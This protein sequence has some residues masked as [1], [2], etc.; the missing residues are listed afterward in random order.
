MSGEQEKTQT[1]KKGVAIRS[2][3]MLLA[4]IVCILTVITI[5]ATHSTNQSYIRM[6]EATERFI[7]AREAA[8]SMQ[9]ASDY[10][11]E[12]ART[13]VITGNRKNVDAFFTE[14]KETRRRDQALESLGSY[15]GETEAYQALRN[16]L[17]G[18]NELVN[19]ENYAMRVAL[20]AY[21]YNV[22]DFPEELRTVELTAADA[23]LDARG[24]LSLATRLVFGEE[25]QAQKTAIYEE[26][27][28][29]LD[30][31]ISRSE[32]GQ[33]ESAQRMDVMLKVRT[34]LLVVI[35]AAFFVL[36]LCSYFLVVK[37]LNRANA[38][39][40]RQEYLPVSGSEEV[41]F[42][43]ETYNQM[44][45]QT[46][47]DQEQL[48]YEASHDS[49][50]GLYNRG[51]FEKQRGE[52]EH[53]NIAMVLADVDRFKTI[54]DT[55]GHDTGDRILKKVAGLLKKSFRSED[56]VCRIGGDEFAVIM[57]HSDSSL[58]G[59]VRDK[60]EKVN[61]ALAEPEDG[62]P[63]VSLSIGVA[64]GDRENPTEDIFKDADTA[65]Y[66]VKNSG[67]NAV[68]FY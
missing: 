63:V 33:E 1:H 47:K 38:L 10:L 40:R 29:C 18:S 66:S 23:A 58:R 55:Y 48:S 3:Y 56:Y 61:A 2:I 51:V 6:Q 34:T 21:G 30:I 54:N 41:R 22:K 11:T 35:L 67:G 27:G 17:D 62:L 20:D 15:Y 42:L 46:R 28:R 50:T 52:L 24:K 59:L 68:A 44:F 12:Q 65:Q 60:M 8:S 43:A 14:I 19:T 16:A 7:G 45:H 57:L 64:F 39:I 9:T 32:A 53:D 4:V 36:V 13:F 26:I 5:A 25:Y 31:L 49:L 37:P